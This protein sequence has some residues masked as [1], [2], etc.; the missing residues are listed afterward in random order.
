MIVAE[1]RIEDVVHVEPAGMTGYFKVK[2][3]LGDRLRIVGWAFG[4]EAAVTAVELVSTGRTVATVAPDTPR[5]DVAETF[6]ESPASLVSGFE[7]EI[8]A[9][10]SGRSEL[11]VEAVTADGTRHDLGSL[12]VTVLPAGDQ[13]DRAEQS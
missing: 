4:E 12:L 9:Q 5:P 6:P 2:D 1:I 13:S 7:L 8:E 11:Q 3:T 10:G